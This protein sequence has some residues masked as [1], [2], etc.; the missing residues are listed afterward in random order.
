MKGN[1]W[2][3]I[4]IAAIAL[5]Y[6]G[7]YFYFMPKYKEGHKAPEFTAE[8]IDGRQFSL[9]DLGGR[10]VLLD[11]WGSWCGPCRQE[12]PLIVQLYMRYQDA[13][14][15]VVSVGIESSA[16]R[17]RQAIERDGLIWDFHIGQFDNFKSPIAQQYGV[18]QLPTKYLIGPHGGIIAVNPSVVE[19]E[20]ILS[21]NL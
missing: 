20:E 5:Y 1:Y 16:E 8:L 4:I 14:F 13:G 17:W 15:T 11:F 3:L 21:E 2:F 6:A 9:S 19:V 18:R 12:N 7:R 10:Y